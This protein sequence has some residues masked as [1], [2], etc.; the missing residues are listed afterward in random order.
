MIIAL[1][2]TPMWALTGQ[3]GITALAARNS[4]AACC[5]EAVVVPTFHPSYILRGNRVE[6]PLFHADITLA[7]KRQRQNS[8]LVEKCRGSVCAFREKPVER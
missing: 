3:S 7:A 5:Q 1:G 4:P 8:H 6:E 2:R